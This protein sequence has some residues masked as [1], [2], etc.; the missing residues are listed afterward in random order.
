ML[1]EPNACRA[2]CAG[3][4]E[5]ACRRTC[6]GEADAPFVENDLARVDSRGATGLPAATRCGDSLGN[7]GVFLGEALL[8]GECLGNRG[9]LFGN[10][11]G[12]ASMDWD[13]ASL[14]LLPD[15]GERGTLRLAGRRGTPAQ[16]QDACSHWHSRLATPLAV[17]VAVG[18]CGRRSES[19][20]L[21]FCP[22]K[23]CLDSKSFDIDRYFETGKRLQQLCL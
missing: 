6:A 12:F 5:A 20:R 11:A 8:V 17:R 23:Q 14:P 18:T 16:A 9:E 7:R 10:R 22:W 4:A 13:G 15:R 19:K 21:D 2:Q 1:L 3:E